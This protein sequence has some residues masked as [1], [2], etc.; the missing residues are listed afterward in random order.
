MQLSEFRDTRD[1]GHDIWV[2]VHAALRP[3]IPRSVLAYLSEDRVLRVEAL[4]GE[5]IFDVKL[6]ISDALMLAYP[7]DAYS[8]VYREVFHHF[9][10]RP[11]PPI[12][13]HIL[14]GAD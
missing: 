10:N 9:R 5:K 6:H 13:D 4:F 2:V 1:V 12:E 14:L 7:T 3:F 11:T 8:T